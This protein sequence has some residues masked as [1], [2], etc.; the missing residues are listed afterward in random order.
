MGGVLYIYNPLVVVIVVVHYACLDLRGMRIE[1]WVW[2]GGMS[3]HSVSVRNAREGAEAVCGEMAV[4]GDVRSGM[5]WVWEA[6]EAMRG[7][8]AGARG[9]GDI[10]EMRSIY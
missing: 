7:R 8:Y 3:C 10:E 9:S 6:N 1:G 2:Q 5:W 4:E